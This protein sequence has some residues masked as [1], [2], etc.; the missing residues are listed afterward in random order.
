MSEKIN[1]LFPSR[2]T[3]ECIKVLNGKGFFIVRQSASH[4]IM[5]ND[6]G[7]TLPPIV[8]NREQAIGTLRKIAKVAFPDYY[9][10]QG[11]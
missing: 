6:K 5:R 8:D 9:K 11:V 2:K 1:L 3:S 4:I 7:L 10:Q